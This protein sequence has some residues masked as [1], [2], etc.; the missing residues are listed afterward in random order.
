M[1]PVMFA[2]TSIHQ[3][4]PDVWAAAQFQRTRLGHCARRRRLMA[5]ARALAERPG[6]TIPELFTRKYDIDATYDLLDQPE[7]TPDAIQ[8]GHRHLVK[9]E[10]RQPGRYLLIEDT[11]FPSFSHRRQ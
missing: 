6:A 2:W 11:T 9:H 10:L 5:Y 1:E 4:A 7:V 8:G 3:A